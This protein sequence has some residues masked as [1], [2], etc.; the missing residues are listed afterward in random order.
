MKKPGESSDIFDV[1][2]H[3]FTE[4]VLEASHQRPIL[5]DFWAEWC[6]PCLILGPVLEGVVKTEEGRFALAKL[7]VDD[8]MRLAGRYRVRGFPTVIAF[9]DGE[10][11]KR[12]SWAQPKHV[13]REFI[14][15][16]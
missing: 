14:E 6:S 2:E 12:F 15:E 3:D 4:R 9:V 16:I 10:E 13:I 1:N 11:I 8:N 5:V 7:E